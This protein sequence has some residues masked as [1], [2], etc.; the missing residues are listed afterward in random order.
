MDLAGIAAFGTAWA[1]WIGLLLGLLALR[2]E[3]VQR[4]RLVLVGV[5]PIGG[6]QRGPLDNVVYLDADGRPRERW[7]AHVEV[8]VA[9][10]NIG[11]GLAE[12]VVAVVTGISGDAFTHGSRLNSLAQTI[13]PKEAPVELSLRIQC[14]VEKER[15]RWTGNLWILGDRGAV[16]RSAFTLLAEGDQVTVLPENAT[17]FGSARMWLLRLRFRRHARRLASTGSASV[18]LQK[19]EV[20]LFDALGTREWELTGVP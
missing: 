6:L 7:W 13:L 1:A 11:D 20:E 9:V 5:K 10:R 8:R 3:I 19:E 15:V 12:G 17:A 2:R 14:L 18:K 16:L 4:P